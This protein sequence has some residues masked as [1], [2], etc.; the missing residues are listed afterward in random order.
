MPPELAEV[1]RWLEKARR[2]RLMAE[3]GLARTPPVTDAAA[4][5]CQQ[6]VE[7]TLKAYL[8]YREHE[9]ERIHD[10]RELAKACAQYDQAFGELAPVVDPLTPY[11][12]RFRYPGSEDPTVEQIEAA[13][14]VVQEVWDFVANRLPREAWL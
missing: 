7:K 1:R 3:S 4:F 14:A 8:V 13:M 2:D 12:V 5:H 11:A 10:L 9:F 6:S